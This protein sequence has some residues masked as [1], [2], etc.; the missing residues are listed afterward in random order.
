ML[1]ETIRADLRVEEAGSIEAARAAAER[2]GIHL[3]LLDLKLP[4]TTGLGALEALR[5]ELPEVPVVV[6]SGEHDANLVRTAVE[7]GAMGFIPKSLTPDRLV[8]ALRQ[9][10]DCKVYLPDDPVSAPPPF[11]IDRLPE[12]TERQ[13]EVLRCVVQG[14]SNKRVARDLGVSSETV[15][16][17]LAAAMRS[18]RASNRTELVYIAARRGLRLS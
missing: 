15:K 18:L 4:G 9:V 5:A 3:V 16:T 7:R 17:H 10:L 1:I 2:G 11:E 12:L 8:E 6:I 14:K 13:M